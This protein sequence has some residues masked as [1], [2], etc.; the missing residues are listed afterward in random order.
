MVLLLDKENPFL[1]YLKYQLQFPPFT[2]ENAVSLVAKG[3]VIIYGWGPV[4]IRGGKHFRERSLFMD[5]R[6]VEIGGGKNFSARKL[7]GASPG[8]SKSVQWFKS[9]RILKFYKKPQKFHVLIFGI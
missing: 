9:H 1:K 5:G 2:F 7:R 8:L 6:A 3:M 4:Q